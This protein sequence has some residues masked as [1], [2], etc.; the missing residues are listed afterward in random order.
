M[1]KAVKENYLTLLEHC[2]HYEVPVIVSSDAHFY[3][4]IANHDRAISVIKEVGF[5]EDLVANANLDLLAKYIPA[6]KG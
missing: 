3:T 2:K 6:V 1:G 4:N 5:P